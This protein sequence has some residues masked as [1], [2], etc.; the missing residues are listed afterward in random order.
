MTNLLKDISTL[1]TIN[2]SSLQKLLNFANFCICDAVEETTLTP[3][4][5][6]TVIDLGIGILSILV[7]DNVIKYKFTPSDKLEESIR[8]VVTGDKNL[9]VAKAEKTL[10]SKITNVYKELL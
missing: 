3:D 5:N 4:T 9:F 1:S 6:I 2:E 10:V 8:N 7:D